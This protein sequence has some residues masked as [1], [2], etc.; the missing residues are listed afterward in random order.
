V[1]LV[2]T[3]ISAVSQ[4]VTATAQTKET[5][6]GGRILLGFGAAPF[7]QLPALTVDDQ[8]F[9]HRRG[10][11]LS[12]YTLAIT[13]GSFLGPVASGFVADDMGWRCMLSHLFLL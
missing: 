13:M 8:F 5:F 11:G 1:Y 4:I 9:V 10:L 2:S 6:I 3:I 7:E 12:I